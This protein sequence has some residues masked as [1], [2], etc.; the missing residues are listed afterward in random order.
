M[1]TQVQYNTL[2]KEQQKSGVVR[3]AALKAGMHRETATR[4]LK[5]QTGP[6]EQSQRRRDERKPRCYRTRADTLV[7]LW[8][9][10]LSFLETTPELASEPTAL[11]EYLVANRV[12]QAQG[13]RLRTFQDRMR[14]WRAQNGPPK[15]VF[16]P[17]AQEPG[18]AVQYDWTCA[19]ELGVTIAGQPFKHLLGHTVY[20]FSNWEWAVPCQTESTL[21]LRV[22]LQA[23]LWRMGAVAREQWTD[24]SSTAT[25][26]I[27]HGK[28]ARE[29][30]PAYLAFA[31]HLG[32]EPRTINIGCPHEQGDVEAANRHLKRRIKNHLLLRGSSDFEREAGYWQ[33][34]AEI[35]AAANRVRVVKVEEERRHLRPLPA[36]RYPESEQ[37]GVNVSSAST[38]RVKKN[39]YSVPAKLI[40]LKLEAH[41]S[42]SDVRFTHEGHEVWQC[43]RALGQKPRIDYRHVITWLARK[44]GAFRSYLYREEMFPTIVFRQA[45]D[46]LLANDE[47]TADRHYL[48]VL[49]LAANHGETKIADLIGDCL[50]LGE[51]PLP[52]RV[53]SRLN[54]APVSPFNEAPLVPDPRSYDS[55]LKEAS[56]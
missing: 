37:I 39:T 33:F 47:R 7:K 55:L 22:G 3:H 21:S 12:E 44:P 45:Y 29:F 56:A 24:N 23:G 36:M 46:R 28:Q 8:P 51:V 54:T 53:R 48:R 32:M 14:Q 49:E 4:Y 26:T 52:E 25:H 34:L 38:V 5:A 40:G 41:V 15:E 10:A 16:F 18:K 20:P 17:Q 30:N 11:F 19:N 9:E 35:C 13:A 6:T 31:K 43:P 2:M 50:R 1:I 27:E 42:E